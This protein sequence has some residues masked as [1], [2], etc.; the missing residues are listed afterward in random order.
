MSIKELAKLI[1]VGLALPLVFSAVI[2]W[3]S[4][5]SPLSSDDQF[6]WNLLTNTLRDWEH[7]T[8]A[9]AFIRAEECRDWE[10]RAERYR[11]IKRMFIHEKVDRY[12]AFCRATPQKAK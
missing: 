8:E 6:E 10:V 1:G 5:C 3:R 2:I 9:N 11:R 7:P 4:Q 12:A